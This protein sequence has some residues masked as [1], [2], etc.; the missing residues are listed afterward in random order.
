LLTRTVAD[1][2]IGKLEQRFAEILDGDPGAA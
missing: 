1:D 2:L